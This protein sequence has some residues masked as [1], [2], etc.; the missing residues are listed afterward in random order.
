MTVPVVADA[1]EEAGEAA[2]DVAAGV[3]VAVA[4]ALADQAGQG[5]INTAG[6]LT[7]QE[8]TQL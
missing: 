6:R 2:A 5:D 1:T 7:E 8:R 4:V 3:A